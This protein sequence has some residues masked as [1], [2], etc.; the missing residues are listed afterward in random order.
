MASSLAAAQIRPIRPVPEPPPISETA[1]AAHPRVMEGCELYESQEGVQPSRPMTRR[2]GFVVLGSILPLRGAGHRR[3]GRPDQTDAEHEIRRA[4]FPRDVEHRRGRPGSDGRRDNRRVQRAPKPG[5]EEKV[6]RATR[7]I[8]AEERLVGI[9]HHRGY[10][11]KPGQSLRNRLPKANGLRY[12]RH[13]SLLSG[14]RLRLLHL[15][16]RQHNP[17]LGERSLFF[18]PRQRFPGTM[19]RSTLSR[20]G[21]NLPPDP[22]HRATPRPE[23]GAGRRRSDQ[24]TAEH[25][26]GPHPV[27]RA[28]RAQWGHACV[29]S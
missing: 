5:S 26:S 25:R 4:I 16:K 27:A 29:R 19:R 20:E 17:F 7:G 11:I 6:A 28:R 13:H 3:G 2:G 12:P 24:R 18:T 8:L 22:R 14:N 21:E 9:V 10:V 15:A 1:S 23:C